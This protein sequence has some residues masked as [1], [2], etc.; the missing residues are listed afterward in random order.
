LLI[1][2]GEPL[3]WTQASLG[4]RGHAIEARIYAE[5]PISHLPQA[6]LLLLYREPAMPGVRIDSGVVEGS[7]VSVH[8]DPLLAKLIASGET[9]EIARRRAVAA[10]KA[11]PILGI[12]TNIPVLVELLEHPRFISGALDTRLVDDETASLSEKLSSEP[13]PSV[14]AIAAAAKAAGTAS[15]TRAGAVAADTDPWTSLRG[16]RV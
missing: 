13:P 7:E 10:L 14:I 4:Q 1:A 9:R 12:R 3:S 5:D 15:S 6:G 16:I 2:S 11:F 8:Y